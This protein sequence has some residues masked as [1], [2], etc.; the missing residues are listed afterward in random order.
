[1]WHKQFNQIM[2]HFFSAVLVFFPFTAVFRKLFLFLQQPFNAASIMLH[3]LL[4]SCSRGQNCFR[5]RYFHAA[6]KKQKTHFKPKIIFFKYF[7]SWLQCFC[8]CQMSLNAKGCVIKLIKLGK[9]YK[10]LFDVIDLHMRTFAKHLRCSFE[11]KLQ[12]EKCFAAQRT[13]ACKSISKRISSLFWSVYVCRPYN[14]FI[15]VQNH[16][17]EPRVKNILYF[18]QKGN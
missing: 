4:C 2:S 16:C 15:A 7:R 14:F 12:N 13:L 5:Y 11:K 6:I 10:I 8:G 1:M 9:S 3:W 18:K 17:I